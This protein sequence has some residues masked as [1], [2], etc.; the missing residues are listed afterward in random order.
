MKIKF[1]FLLAFFLIGSSA[2]FA[3]ANRGVKKL[4][5]FTNMK[6]SGEHQT[7]TSVEL[8]Q[9]NN[10]VFG[11]FLSSDGLA[12]DTPT[13]L[14]EDVTY[15]PQSGRLTFRARLSTGMTIDKGGKEVPS[16]DVF[17]FA[18]MLA[19]RTLIGTLTHTDSAVKPATRSKKRVT[20]PYSKRET[21]QM[22]GSKTYQEWKK[23][24]DEILALRGP[25]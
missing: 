24:A 25:K 16:R 22:D 15:E 17:Q 12:G 21:A 1:V 20:L 11:L 9:E 14:L 19:K 8:W 5:V 6:F 4:G 3:Q 13:G 18:G 7:G 2:A 10:R 23:S